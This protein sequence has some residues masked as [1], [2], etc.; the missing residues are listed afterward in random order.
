MIIKVYASGNPS[1]LGA[2]LQRITNLTEVRIL[3][4][5]LSAAILD[6]D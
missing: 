5:S 3:A 2:F 1:K 4:I 6:F